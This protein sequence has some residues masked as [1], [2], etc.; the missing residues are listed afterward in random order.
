MDNGIGSFEPVNLVCSLTKVAGKGAMNII[1]CDLQT[2]YRQIAWLKAAAGELVTRRLEHE[3]GEAR[4]FYQSL[5][6]G[7]RVG[8]EATLPAH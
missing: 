7:A 6:S 5:P 4:A 2:R 3:N 1:G 8:I